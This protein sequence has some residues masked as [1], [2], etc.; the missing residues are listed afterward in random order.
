M[1]SVILLFLAGF[2][3]SGAVHFEPNIGQVAGRTQWIARSGG[4]TMYIAPDKVVHALSPKNTKQGDQTRN[5]PMRL[6]RARK[7]ARVEGNEL[8]A[9]VIL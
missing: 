1:K 6:V 8:T 2:A 5:V 4:V 7:E 9:P 3:M